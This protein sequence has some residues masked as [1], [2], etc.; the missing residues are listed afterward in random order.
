MNE[1]ILQLIVDYGLEATVIALAINILTGLLKLPIKA[2]ASKMQD[3][4]QL[5]KYL[6]F[7][8][9]ILGFVLTM[10]YLWLISGTVNLNYTFITMWLSASSLSLSLYAVWEKLFPSKKKILEKNEVE[11]NFKLIEEIR[12]LMKEKEHVESLQSQKR[13]D[14]IPEYTKEHRAKIIL[15]GNQ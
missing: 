12:A 2:W 7:L 1:Q 3:G 15:K 14:A 10:G 6:V 5:T 11:Q 13:T 4:T 9:I 8:P